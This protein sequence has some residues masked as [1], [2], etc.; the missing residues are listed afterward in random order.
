MNP[1]RDPNSQQI[2]EIDVEK[3]GKMKVEKSNVTTRSGSDDDTNLSTSAETKVNHDIPATSVLYKGR[4]ARLN[5]NIEGLSGL[6]ARG[7]TRVL[8]EERHSCGRKGYFQMFFLWF[9]VNLVAN[10]TI[11]GLLGPSLFY[12]SWK[13]S[14]CIAI[15]ANALASCGPAYTSTFSTRSGNRTMVCSKQNR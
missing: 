10:N 12:L 14:V 9:I 11:I 8:P 6:E 13:D 5:A 7:I 3:R 2:L 4:L 15:F 1:L